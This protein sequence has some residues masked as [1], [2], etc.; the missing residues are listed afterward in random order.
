L[1]YNKR[2]GQHFIV[3]PFYIERI[4]SISELSPEDIVLEIGTGHGILTKRLCERAKTVISYEVDKRLFEISK[5][6]LASYKNLILVNGDGLKTEYSFNKVVSNLPY[7]I[8]RRFIYW[9]SKKSFTSAVVT[10]QKDFVEK[11]VSAPSS[12]SYR[13]VSVISQLAFKLNIYD[14]IPPTAFHPPPKVYSYIV[15]LEP[16]PY[17]ILDDRIVKTINRIFAFR[18]KKVSSLVKHFHKDCDSKLK[19]I[20]CEKIDLEKRVENLSPSECLLL[21]KFLLK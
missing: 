10:L 18:G 14:K 13:A 16:K 19:L 7:S 1:K 6:S 2:L 20:K 15:K 12:R 3:E 8:S 17:S 9:L 5:R 4:I 11:L 21:A